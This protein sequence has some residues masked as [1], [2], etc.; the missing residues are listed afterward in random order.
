MFCVWEILCKIKNI[1]RRG[2]I[3]LSWSELRQQKLWCE[4]IN[5]ARKDMRIDLQ[6]FHY[7]RASTN[8]FKAYCEPR[9]YSQKELKCMLLTKKVF[10]KLRLIW[11]LSLSWCFQEIFVNNCN[12]LPAFSFSLLFQ[13][14]FLS[15]KFFVVLF[16]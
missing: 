2:T 3:Y 5:C 13:Y 16:I 6:L 7:L 4:V 14:I 12:V 1:I 10:T 11:S 8:T 15:S 9:Y